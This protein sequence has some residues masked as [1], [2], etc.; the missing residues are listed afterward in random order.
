MGAYFVYK[1]GFDLK[2]SEL[3]KEARDFWVSTKSVVL[4]ESLKNS[5]EERQEVIP[6]ELRYTGGARY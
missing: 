2:N 1:H 6:E 3:F 4:Q 5:F